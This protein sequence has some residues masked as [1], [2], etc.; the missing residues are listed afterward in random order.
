MFIY[1]TKASKNATNN[2]SV[3]PYSTLM[4]TIMC[5][6]PIFKTKTHCGWNSSMNFGLGGWQHPNNL[7]TDGAK[8]F[9]FVTNTFFTHNGKL[10]T[11]R[12]PATNLFES[13]H[14]LQLLYS[15][16]FLAGAQE[17]IYCQITTMK[18]GM[19]SDSI[20]IR[21]HYT[22]YINCV[23]QYICL[24]LYLYVSLLMCV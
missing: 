17:A 5:L 21:E 2:Y 9:K 23:I 12:V 19:I 14:I 24:P 16:H 20:S 8:H 11:V 22:M 1:K 10:L 7:S 18:Y 15:T 13:E 4:S 6:L 3:K